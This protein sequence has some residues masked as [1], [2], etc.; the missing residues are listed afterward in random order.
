MVPKLESSVVLAK[1]LKDQPASSHVLLV[2]AGRPNYYAVDSFSILGD[3]V[4]FYRGTVP[5]ANTS[6][7]YLPKMAQIV[8]V[9][10]LKEGAWALVERASINVVTEKALTEQ[11]HADQKAMETFYEGLDP[12]AWKE[13]QE[14]AKQGHGHG[15]MDLASLLGGQGAPRGAAKAVDDGKPVP[16]QYL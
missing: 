14:L 4:V 9:C 2:G 3:T 16:G 6:P 8:Y 1:D 10:R 15:G 12:E 5:Y 11:Q 13:A 7:S